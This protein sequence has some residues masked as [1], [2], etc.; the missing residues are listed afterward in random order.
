MIVALHCFLESENVELLSATWRLTPKAQRT[1][2]RVCREHSL[3]PEGF[4]EAVLL[5]AEND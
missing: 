5:A 1:F 2:N 3:T 4:L